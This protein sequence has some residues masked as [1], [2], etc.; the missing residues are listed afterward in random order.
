MPEKPC[1]YCKGIGVQLLPVRAATAQD[2]NLTIE[3]RHG[4]RAVI[5]PYTAG[6]AE[7]AS[8]KYARPES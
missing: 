1:P 4:G 6:K 2:K 5:E 3:N 8:N 7:N